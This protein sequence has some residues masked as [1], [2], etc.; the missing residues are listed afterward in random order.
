LFD[1]DAHRIYYQPALPDFSSNPETK[2]AFRI[3]RLLKAAIRVEPNCREER[4]VAPIADKRMVAKALVQPPEKMYTAPDDI[5]ESIIV[6]KPTRVVKRC[7]G[8]TAQVSW[9]CSLS[10]F[11]DNGSA[12]NGKRML[13]KAANR[14]SRQ[15]EGPPSGAAL[16]L[17]GLGPRFGPIKSHQAECITAGATI[18]V[19]ATEARSN[20]Q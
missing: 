12:E 19:L 5:G 4:A 9:S 16:P 15:K 20:R 17:S 18:Q 6:L 11:F 3:E 2:R 7:V 10:L 8:D 1:C 14:H 13:A